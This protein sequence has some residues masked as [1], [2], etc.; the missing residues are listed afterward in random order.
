M[1]I[2][3]I[4]NY[5]IYNYGSVLQS[6]ALQR[7]LQHLGIEV[8]TIAYIDDKTTFKQKI[9]IIFYVKMQQLCLDKILSKIRERRDRAIDGDYTEII[10]KRKKAYDNFVNHNFALTTECQTRE[11]V[12]HIIE[13]CQGVILSSDQL[14]GPSDIIRGYHTLQFLPSQVKKIA[15][16]TSFG[17]SSEP[18]YFQKKISKFIPRFSSVSVRERSGKDL[19]SQI[20][21][22][23]VPVLID[24]TML[25]KA[26]EWENIARQSRIKELKGEYIFYY[27]LGKRLDNVEFVKKIKNKMKVCMVSILHAETYNLPS[28]R[29]ADKYIDGVGPAEFLWLI[30]NAKYVITDSFH[31]SV[32][33]ILFHKNFITLDRYKTSDG[34]SRNTRIES[35]LQ[36]FELE[37]RHCAENG[38]DDWKIIYENINWDKVYEILERERKRSQEYLVMAMEQ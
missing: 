22:I 18:R 2:A 11:D 17:V 35:L 19:I 7:Y 5:Y 33:S 37:E 3:L 21:N 16:A 32:F 34:L 26:E 24:P 31:A 20:C 28:E 36:T 6:L 13:N 12:L 8:G 38:E 23:D 9:E 30:L 25:L 4:C 1:K 14:W 10:N 29:I 15:Y 27:V